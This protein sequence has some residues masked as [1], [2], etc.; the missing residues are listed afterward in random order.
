[1]DSA[2]GVLRSGGRRPVLL[3]SRSVAAGSA[4]GAARVAAQLRRRAGSSWASDDAA[5]ARAPRGTFVNAVAV[6]WR[7]G[8][9]AGRVV[10]AGLPKATARR[11][12]QEAVR[13]VIGRLRALRARTP[14]QES[15]ARRA[16]S[17]PTTR[18]V[19]TAFSIAFGVRVPGI[20]APRA[21]PD[22]PTDGTLALHGAITR[23]GA[24]QP[25]QRRVVRRVLAGL[26]E[27][28][29]GTG[30]RAAIESDWTPSPLYQAK[31]VDAA[32]V[33][34]V[35]LGFPLRLALRVGTSTV[36]RKDNALAVTEALSAAF[37]TSGAPKSCWI[38]VHP[39][40]AKE[41]GVFEK[42][43]ITHEVFH[44]FQAQMGNDLGKF[45]SRSSAA[46]DWMIEGGADWAACSAVPNPKPEQAFQEWLDSPSTALTDRV[47]AG[48]G[49]FLL[50][51][52]DGV[53]LWPRWP[54]IAKAANGA[55]AFEAAAGTTQPILG[56]IWAP[57]LVQEPARGASWDPGAVP[58][59]PTEVSFPPI[60]NLFLRDG[61]TAYVGAQPY[62]ARL[63][64]VFSD[65]DVIHTALPD[66]QARLSSDRPP[67]DET[68]LHD[69][70]Y[71]TD[72]QSDCSC[73]ANS[74]RAGSPP[75]RINGDGE[76][77]IAVTGGQKGVAGKV[78]GLTR[79][80][81][82]GVK[83]GLIVPGRSIG[84]VYLGQT[85]KSLLKSVAGLVP[86]EHGFTTKTANGLLLR[87][88]ALIGIV[89]QIHFGLCS[90]PLLGGPGATA[91]RQQFPQ[92]KPDQVASV[93][94]SSTSYATRDGLGPGSD[95]AAVVSSVGSGYCERE[96]GTPADEQPWHACHVPTAGGGSTTWGFT[97]TKAGANIVLAVAVFNP[98][99]IAD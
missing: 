28:G 45:Y 69:R 39:P 63:V 67:L 35:R 79:E 3:V 51:G 68:Q 89:F 82:C 14:W 76:T 34:G 61:Q 49:F 90:S 93:Q 75:P 98:K 13:R 62:A 57:S 27:A 44:C 32:G 60:Q 85:R 64:S 29:G 15:Q 16:G 30:A 65:A 8:S 31:A 88:D 80:Q 58:C 33:L 87:G 55:Q 73:P 59:R 37:T 56:R 99:A 71:C 38:T 52:D 4:A 50:L 91:C 42:E 19:L 74:A 54:T 46:L 1:M 21:R 17:L 43:I 40:G 83:L 94:T 6:F 92:S 36:L 5:A 23:L 95:A 96:E 81:Y 9:S 84:D 12:A 41:T 24:M 70:Y 97:T 47:Y 11:L 53:D 48:V 78:E 86:I 77:I 66:D 22:R 26:H 20:P 7:S 2:L 72:L 25:A 10:V 18:D